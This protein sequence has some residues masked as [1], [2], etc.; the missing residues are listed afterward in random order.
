MCRYLAREIVLYTRYP[1]PLIS[2]STH[3]YIGSSSNHDQEHL[4]CY[5][6]MLP[7]FRTSRSSS[8]FAHYEFY[9][10]FCLLLLFATCLAYAFSQHLFVVVVVAIWAQ[11]CFTGFH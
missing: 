10:P 7:S 4:H 9:Y 1:P 6:L 11:R 2:H 3:S 8:P 5:D